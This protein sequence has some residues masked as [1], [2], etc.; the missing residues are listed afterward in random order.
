M[1]KKSDNSTTLLR[2]CVGIDVSKDSLQICL[3]TIDT[4]GKTIVKGTSKVAN[5]VCAFDGLLTWTAK[6]CKEKGLPVRYLMESTGVYHEQ[7]AW[8]LFQNDLSVIVILPNKSKNYLKSLGHNR[9]AG[10]V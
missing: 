9:A 7:I 5:K 3:S 6:H 8:Y 4:A 1:D 2:Y 10:A